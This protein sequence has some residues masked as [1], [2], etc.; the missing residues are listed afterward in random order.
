MARRHVST[1]SFNAVAAGQVATLDLPVG[2]LVYHEIRLSYDT[3]TAGGATLAN[4]EA[5]IERIRVK[6]D[7][8]TQLELT[9]EQL[10]DLNTLYGRPFNTGAATDPALLPIILA[11]LGR[12]TRA[13]QGEDALAWGTADLSSLQVEV[14]I[15]SGAT[16]PVLSAKVVVDDGRR[17]MGPIVKFRRVTVPVTA[18]GITTVTTFPKGD[19]YYAIHC[20][21]SVLDDVEV[22]IDQREAFKA[23]LQELQFLLEDNGYT[24]VS[25]LV[26]LRFDL[27]Q[28]VADA[29]KMRRPDGR[30]V[31]EFR[32]DFNMSAA[33]SFT[34]ILETVGL[35]D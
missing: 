8:K 14:Q 12:N 1:N 27:T 3:A 10:I 6:A 25:G 17:P 28:R 24:W 32:V 34:A 31:S 20:W 23:T 7:G 13:A 19:D 33:T 35:R 5:E 15:A 18:T 2:D 16:S 30:G 22:K 11:P 29:L 21:S 9:A 26:P 4:V